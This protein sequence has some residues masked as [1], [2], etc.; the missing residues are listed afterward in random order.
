[1][2]FFI[3]NQ[4]RAR[5]SGVQK[6]IFTILMPLFIQHAR[7]RVCSVMITLIDRPLLHYYVISMPLSARGA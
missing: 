4:P 1:M 3:E 6:I 2:M 5:K 7:E